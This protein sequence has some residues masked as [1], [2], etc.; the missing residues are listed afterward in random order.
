[1]TRALR[2]AATTVLILTL[3]IGL[4]G[5]GSDGDRSEPEGVTPDTLLF[6]GGTG[7]AKDAA[8]ADKEFD[9]NIGGIN[10]GTSGHF[11]SLD[12]YEGS[13][14]NHYFMT[15]AGVSYQV[16]VIAEGDNKDVDL[17]L[18]R[19]Q[20][21]YTAGNWASSTRSY[22]RM[23]GVVFKAAQ[24]GLMYVDVRGVDNNGQLGE[25]PYRIHVRKCQFATY[26]Q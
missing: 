8:P 14:D 10:L 5:C 25:I 3:A 9:P 12:V 24:D 11:Y 6:S 16:E 22:P 13:V 26:S 23:D 17:F 19:S 21:P 18:S 15:K 1:M 7:D 4:I 2:C 20:H